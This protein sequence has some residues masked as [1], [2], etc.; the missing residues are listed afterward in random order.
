MSER[1]SFF[2]RV[3]YPGTVGLVA[4]GV[5]LIFVVVPSAYS[6][7]SRL[8]GHPA[9]DFTLGVVYN[10]EAGNRL[11]L[12]DL[13]GHAV[14]LDFYAHWCGPCQIQAPILDR[15]AQR[16]KASGLVV[17]GVNT[18][19]PPGYGAQ[20]ARQKHLSYPIVYDD[21]KSVA[22]RYAVSG[23][24]T[25]VVIDRKGDVVTVRSGVEDEAELDRLVR[26]AL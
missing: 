3:V 8:V 19:D 21:D 14:I 7:P 1:E 22:G 17:V 6:P 5:L 15:V 12:S 25:L 24:P 4:I 16:H 23:L 11:R 20:F 13:K 26:Q 9:P 18:D 10:G 2:S